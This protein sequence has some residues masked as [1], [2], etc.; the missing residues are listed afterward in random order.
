MKQKN[1][2]NSLCLSVAV[3]LTLL[4]SGCHKDDASYSPGTMVIDVSQAY[5]YYF[6]IFREAETAWAQVHENGY[7]YG[8]KTG[9]SNRTIQLDSLNKKI[10]I[11]VH[12]KDY[13]WESTV[14]S[15]KFTIALTADSSYLKKDKAT[16]S[17]DSLFIN[18][19]KVEGFSTITHTLNEETDQYSYILA[20]G[21]IYSVD[22]EDILITSAVSG[23]TLLRTAGSATIATPED[24]VWTFT[25]TMTGKIRNSESLKYSNTVAVGKDMSQNPP[26]TVQIPPAFYYDCSKKAR[27]GA[28]ILTVG[29][30]E[31]FYR[32]DNDCES[33][34]QVETVTHNDH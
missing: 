34:I 23:G 21:S 14:L 8:E 24:D 6:I 2:L 16:I 11:D 26:V 22:G 18:K 19:Q 32:Y 29:G 28:C 13:T 20:S 15:G 4:Q 12:L 7:R 1:I 25:G 9:N 27:Q 31:I 3:V 30:R 10:Y 33:P 5:M 17:L